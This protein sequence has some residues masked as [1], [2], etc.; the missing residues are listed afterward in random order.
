ML[1]KA[2]VYCYYFCCFQFVLLLLALALVG[3]SAIMP[4]L[5]APSDSVVW[6]KTP[7]TL[8][9]RYEGLDHLTLVPGSISIAFCMNII[10]SARTKLD[11]A[12]SVIKIGRAS[13]RERV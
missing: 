7:T 10:T 2:T 11:L 12:V 1:N 5:L 4:V 9:G 3:L 6:L 13:C 8:Y